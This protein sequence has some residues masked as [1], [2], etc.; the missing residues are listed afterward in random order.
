MIRAPWSVTPARPAQSPGLI[1]AGIDEQRRSRTFG[2]PAT[3]SADSAF[4]AQLAVTPGG[5]LEVTYARLVDM[6]G[7]A[8]GVFHRRSTDGGATFW[9]RP[10]SAWAWRARV[11]L[12]GPAVSVAG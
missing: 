8:M 4:S 1:G 5:A 6:R 11:P 2:P 7:A 3:V 9:A 10:C 12:E